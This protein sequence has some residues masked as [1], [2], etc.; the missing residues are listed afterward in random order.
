[1]AE[2]GGIR[3]SASGD[4]VDIMGNNFLIRDLLLIASGNDLDDVISSDLERVSARVQAEA[5]DQ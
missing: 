5:E 4:H 1:M 2:G 3:G